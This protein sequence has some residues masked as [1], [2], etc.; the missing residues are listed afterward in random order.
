MS[1]N[2]EPSKQA[3]KVVFTQKIDKV[4]YPSVF[5]NGK[6]IYQVSSQRDLGHILDTFLTFV[7]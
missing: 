7:K 2:L 1:I 4:L 6:P 5:F 3:Q